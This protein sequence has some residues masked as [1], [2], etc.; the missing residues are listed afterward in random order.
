MVLQH[1]RHKC[2]FVCYVS[3]AMLQYNW[4]MKHD[5]Q[6]DYC[7]KMHHLQQCIHCHATEPRTHRTRA[8]SG[9]IPQMPQ[10]QPSMC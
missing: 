8:L 9:A 10:K 5:T 4:L 6:N 1:D 3:I 2:K 7:Q